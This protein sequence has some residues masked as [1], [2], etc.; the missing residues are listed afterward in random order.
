M[1]ES[2]KNEEKHWKR[3]REKG[4]WKDLREM[5]VANKLHFWSFK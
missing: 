1:D 5:M 4:K 3:A 2:G